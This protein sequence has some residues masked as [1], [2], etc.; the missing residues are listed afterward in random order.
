MFESFSVCCLGFGLACA[1][2]ALALN[3]QERR[4]LNAA[5]IIRR[6]VEPDTRP[7]FLD[8][9]YPWKHDQW[10]KL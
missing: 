9:E 7:Y 6:I 5:A 3:H 2:V 4:R 10:W 8:T 1:F